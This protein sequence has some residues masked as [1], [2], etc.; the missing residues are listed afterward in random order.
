[1]EQVSCDCCGR[2]FW[3][4]DLNAEFCPECKPRRQMYRKWETCTKTGENLGK[5][6]FDIIVAKRSQ[7]VTVYDILKQLREK[8]GINREG[9]SNILS[10]LDRTG[11]LVY[12]DNNKLFPYK[13]MHTGV[14]YE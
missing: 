1:M 7:G 3:T 9:T 14:T 11:Y 13:D 2:W 8:Y 6:I 4:N 10:S 12:L 5:K